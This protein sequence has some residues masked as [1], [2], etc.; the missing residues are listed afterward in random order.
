MLGLVYYVYYKY[1]NDNKENVSKY[2]D[3]VYHP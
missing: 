3:Y 2:Y 1:M